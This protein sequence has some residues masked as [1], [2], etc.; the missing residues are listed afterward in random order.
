M[1]DPVDNGLVIGVVV[2]V[3]IIALSMAICWLRV[4]IVNDYET[5]LD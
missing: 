1:G 4:N 3:L 2:L 5:V